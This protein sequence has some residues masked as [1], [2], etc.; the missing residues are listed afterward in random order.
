MYFFSVLA[1]CTVI[2][3]FNELSN[4]SFKDPFLERGCKGTHF[5]QTCKR[6]RKNFW[7]FFSRRSGWSRCDS[8]LK[9]LQPAV[10]QTGV[11]RYDFFHYFQIFFNA[12]RRP[13][14]QKTCPRQTNS[15][16]AR[17]I[18]DCY[19]FVKTNK[20]GS[21]T[22]QHPFTIRLCVHIPSLIQRQAFKYQN[23]LLYL[24][25]YIIY[26]TPLIEKS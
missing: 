18:H 15:L 20:H 12:Q 6:F 25:T 11:Q 9:N 16:D 19:D 8:L 3:L 5:F 2:S 23:S 26:S 13:H 21:S 14:R 22:P 24:H 17:D 1:S 4:S 7:L 10:S